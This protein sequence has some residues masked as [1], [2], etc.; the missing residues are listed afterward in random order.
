MKSGD[1]YSS[2]VLKRSI[3][4]AMYS[5]MVLGHLPFLSCIVHIVWI[6]FANGQMVPKSFNVIGVSASERIPR[7]VGKDIA[8]KEVYKF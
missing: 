8:P 3:H 6:G 5:Q 4:H 1:S 2:L 7:C